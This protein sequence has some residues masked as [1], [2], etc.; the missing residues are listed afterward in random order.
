MLLSQETQAFWVISR[1][2]NKQ[3]DAP[4]V[5]VAEALTTLSCMQQRLGTQRPLLH[6]TSILVQAIILTGKKRVLSK[7]TILSGPQA[8]VMMLTRPAKRVKRARELKTA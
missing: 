6:R 7:K 1:A 2:Y 3:A 8:K 5:S 4:D